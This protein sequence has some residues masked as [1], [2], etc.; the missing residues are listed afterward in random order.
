MAG[1]DLA[2]TL[3]PYQE[4]GLT[5]GLID[6]GWLLSDELDDALS[7]AAWGLGAGQYSGPV[8]SR[9]G[10]HVLYLSEIQEAQSQPFEEVQESIYRRERNRRF[11][12]ALREFIASLEEK[13]YI[14][15]DL[16]PDAVGYRALGSAYQTEDELD[17]FHAPVLATD[18]G[19]GDIPGES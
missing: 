16:P 18:D 3:E 6:L 19:E 17:I 8:A 9:G 14:Q 1:D 2:T 7:E 4:Q 13:S 5:T 11:E 15:E 10:L 12:K